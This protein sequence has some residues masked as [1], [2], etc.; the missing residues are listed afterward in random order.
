MSVLPPRRS[1]KPTVLEAHDLLA[2]RDRGSVNS[3]TLI[4]FE[5]STVEGR[6]SLHSF[7][8]AGAL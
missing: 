8:S 1:P 7:G 3:G 6:V 4:A 2:I 5:E